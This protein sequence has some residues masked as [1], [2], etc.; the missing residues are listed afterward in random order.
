[1]KTREIRNMLK[2]LAKSQRRLLDQDIEHGL[3]MLKAIRNP[4]VKFVWKVK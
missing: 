2:Q 4:N 3:K 1:M